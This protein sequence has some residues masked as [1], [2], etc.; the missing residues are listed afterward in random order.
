[1]HG[2]DGAGMPGG[3]GINGPDE[4]EA[5]EA[6]SAVTRRSLVTLPSPDHE[7]IPELWL[8][9]LKIVVQCIIQQTKQSF[10]S[11]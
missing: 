7:A 6:W 5:A 9:L 10:S 4:L 8:V 2:T 1:M 3:S 11:L